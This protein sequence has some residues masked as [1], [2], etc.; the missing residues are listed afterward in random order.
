MR[1]FNQTIDDRAYA[2]NSLVEAPPGSQA[3]V[4]HEDSDIMCGLIRE[5]ARNRGVR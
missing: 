1:D 4:R 3:A 2:V 5:M